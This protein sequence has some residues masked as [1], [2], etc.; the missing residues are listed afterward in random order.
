VITLFAHIDYLPIDTPKL[1]DQSFKKYV[2]FL[3]SL[4][5]LRSGMPRYVSRFG[6]IYVVKVCKFIQS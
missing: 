3:Q 6:K 5:S 4:M 1:F 2:K